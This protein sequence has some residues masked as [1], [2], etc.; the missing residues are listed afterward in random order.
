MQGS[1]KS[2]SW[3]CW[4]LSLALLLAGSAGIALAQSAST[5]TIVGSVA[6][7]AQGAS[8]PNATVTATN[9]ATRIAYT[10]KTTSSGDYTI[11]YLP[12]G[13]YDVRVEAQG[14]AVGA[15]KGLTLNVG[16]Q[17]TSTSS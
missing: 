8:I 5:A 13:T 11:G 6:D 16:D 7:A 1:R 9:T 4:G 10:A 2:S 14:F 17:E 12:P 15:S 3:R